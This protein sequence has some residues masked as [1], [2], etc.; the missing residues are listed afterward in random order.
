MMVLW[1]VIAVFLFMTSFFLVSFWKKDLSIVDIAWG[2]GFVLVAVL[3]LMLSAES[4]ARQLVMTILVAIWG[5][6]LAVHIFV[7][8]KGKGE[9]FRYA[10]MRSNWGHKVAQKSFTN[11]FMLQ[12][13]LLLIIS[14]PV[15]I[16]HA[17]PTAGLTVLDVLGICIWAIGFLWESIADFQLLMF[18]KDSNNKGKILRDGLWKYSR[19]P[20]YF[21]EA[22]L[23]WGAALIAL[24]VPW[25]WLGLGS[26]A[27]LTFFLLNVSGVPMLES[28]YKEN[29]EYAHYVDHT[30]AFIPWWPKQ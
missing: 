26:A 24:S 15:V 23:W 30:N 8:S 10:Q 17:S 3:S 5:I 29:K 9:D 11:V 12:G 19:H 4:T 16:V 27:L 18:K 20:N 21:G 7:R 22:L 25:G 13:F 28:K 2:L 6:R 1:L 14:Y